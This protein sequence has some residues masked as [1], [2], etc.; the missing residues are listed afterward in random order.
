M[1]LCAIAPLV[2]YHG[3]DKNIDPADGSH[4]LRLSYS[5][6]DVDSINIGIEK[7]GKIL[8]DMMKEEK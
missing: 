4:S 1:W 3:V 5:C 8:S 2:G 6:I 7:L